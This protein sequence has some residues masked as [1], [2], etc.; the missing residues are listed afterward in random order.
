MTRSPLNVLLEMRPALAG[1]A[2]IP[3]ENRLLFRGLALLD[4]VRVTGLLQNSERVLARGLRLGET[5]ATDEQ[6]N[7]LARVIITLEQRLW[8]SRL[9]AVA[10]TVMMLARH[11]CGGAQQLT[12]FEAR[13]FRDFTWR[14]L[15]GRTLRP[16]DFDVLTRK[17][18]RVARV[19]WVA[20]HICGL[21]TRKVGYSMYPRLNTS[22]F[23][24]MIAETTYPA[25]VAK[26][27]RLIVRYHDAIPLLMPHTISDKRFHQASHYRALRKNVA[28]GARFVCVSEATRNDLLSI[29]PQLES[30]S[31]TIHNMVSHDYFDE[32]S[33]VDRVREVIRTR[34][35]FNVQRATDPSARSLWIDAKGRK[36]VP[37]YL[38][39]VSTIEPR[40][41]HLALLSAWE[42]LRAEF[43]PNLKLL[44]VGALGWEHAHIIGK[45]R[46]WIGR[47]AF[48]L[49][50]V[51]SA[52][53][54][55]LYKHAR[56]T[57]CP[58]FAEGFDLSG[59]EAMASGG[60]VIASDISTHR[61]IYLDAAQYFNPYSIEDLVRALREVIEPANSARRGELVTTGASVA[62][63]YSPEVIL[64][65]WR[66]FLD[67][68][69]A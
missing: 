54:R 10:H 47:D 11:L 7:R 52:E 21:L 29:F 28:S 46:P 14:R 23:D 53:L 25:S 2:G 44:V 8:D 38:L 51:P 22:E 36:Q 69:A 68:E 5:L 61:E 16:E 19:P 39:M 55:L 30:R 9:Q 65:K 17:S 12:C 27:T 43:F 48:M 56:A 42:R 59:V 45:F 57:I 58:S 4:G 31:I 32:P 18:F 49:E 66:S 26:K 33:S 62:R 60:A 64:P 63:R 24:V 35:N 1:H 41:N 67:S 6:L 3:Q 34:L 20:M 15:F 37:E 50:D 13:H 40:K